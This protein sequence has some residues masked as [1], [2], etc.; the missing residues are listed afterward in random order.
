MKRRPRIP[1]G[2]QSSMHQAIAQLKKDQRKQVERYREKRA[3]GDTANPLNKQLYINAFVDVQSVAIQERKQ[4]Q[5]Q[6]IQQTLVDGR[7][8]NDRLLSELTKALAPPAATATMTLQ[9]KEHKRNAPQTV[10]RNSSGLSTSGAT[11]EALSG[12]GSWR[13][14]PAPH[15]RALN[16]RELAL[17]C[18]ARGACSPVAFSQATLFSNIPRSAE[19]VKALLNYIRT[20]RQSATIKELVERL[21]QC[22]PAVGSLVTEDRHSPAS[23]LTSI[24]LQHVAHHAHWRSALSLFGTLTTEGLCQPMHQSIALLEA[25]RYNAPLHG[26]PCYSTLRSLLTL[27]QE[28]QPTTNSLS[29]V[30]G[31]PLF[32]L[33]KAPS[34]TWMDVLQLVEMLSRTNKKTKLKYLPDHALGEAIRALHRTGATLP[35]LQS[36]IDSITEESADEGKSKEGSTGSSSSKWEHAEEHLRKPHLYTG[37]LEAAHWEESFRILEHH[38]PAYQCNPTAASY[39]AVMHSMTQGGRWDAALQ[40]YPLLHRKAKASGGKLIAVTAESV[41]AYFR[42]LAIC[43]P[44]E[45]Q[46]MLHCV[47]NLLLSDAE[48]FALHFGS[49]L[50]PQLHYISPGEGP[51]PQTEE[52][53]FFND[54]NTPTSSNKEDTNRELDE[55]CREA[56]RFLHVLEVEGKVPPVV[57][58]Q[59]RRTLSVLLQQT[60]SPKTSISAL[61]SSTTE[62]VS[63]DAFLSEMG[64]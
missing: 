6:R 35:Q 60:E 25:M 2:L 46:R 44:S 54:G 64:M 23:A 42:S 53:P 57:T 51:F 17:H 11:A 31:A 28:Q 40:L 22:Q 10:R 45:K 58:C 59:G 33:L 29:P 43:P 61:E 34:A 3:E 30:L 19:P 4:Q 13:Q 12:F 50:V 41:A 20:S 8:E 14:A 27:L 37:Y 18:I 56:F 9:K 24:V 32:S 5:L 55:Y 63:L 39:A 52:D 21:R 7:S 47:L 36:F 49:S 62:E 15:Q 48:P 1:A 26:V 38:M 16:Y